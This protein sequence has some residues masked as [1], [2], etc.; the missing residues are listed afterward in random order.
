MAAASVTHAYFSFEEKLFLNHELSETFGRLTDLVILHYEKILYTSLYGKFKQCVNSRRWS[1]ICRNLYRQ[2]SGPLLYPFKETFLCL[3]CELV[4]KLCIMIIIR[5]FFFFLH[6][7]GL[8][9]CDT[10]PTENT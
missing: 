9:L 7:F 6:M 8:I 3:L 4:T 5:L 1:A 2:L 10:D